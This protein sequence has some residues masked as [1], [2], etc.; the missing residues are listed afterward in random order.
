MLQQT[1]THTHL[2]L[3]SI[4]N[5]LYCIERHIFRTPRSAVITPKSRFSEH[6]GNGIRRAR[7]RSPMGKFGFESLDPGAFDAVHLYRMSEVI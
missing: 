5:A 2:H 7:N 6:R 1:H 4:V 3:R